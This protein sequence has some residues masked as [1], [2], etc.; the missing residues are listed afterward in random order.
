M[1]EYQHP[2]FPNFTVQAGKINYIGD[3]Y[4]AV[5]G[6]HQKS[7]DVQIVNIDLSATD[8]FDSI[9]HRFKSEMPEMFR[10]YEVVKSIAAPLK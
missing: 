6:R 4:Y 7:A 5:K 2:Y 3:L 10:K 8:D 1:N 9:M